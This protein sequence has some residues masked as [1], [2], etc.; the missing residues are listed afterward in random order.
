MRYEAV[1][2]SHTLSVSRAGG[3][4]RYEVSIRGPKVSKT[5]GR[6]FASTVEAMAQAH[7]FAHSA[8][9]IPCRCDAI[10]WDELLEN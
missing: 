6:N 8:L 2:L 5:Q 4:G 3:R 1:V 7:C 10:R 9:G